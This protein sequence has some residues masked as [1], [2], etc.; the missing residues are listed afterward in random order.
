MFRV[1]DQ[2]EAKVHL[3]QR[4]SHRIGLAR[5]DASE[6][7]DV[8]AADGDQFGFFY[9]ALVRERDR[10]GA[11]LH[12]EA[13]F[14]VEETKQ[15]QV[16]VGCGL[17]GFAVTA[18]EAELEAAAGAGD[19]GQI[20]LAR[21]VVDH[22][23]VGLARLVDGQG[24]AAAA[25][26]QSADA[27]ERQ[28]LRAG[29]QAGPGARRVGLARQQGQTEVGVGQRQAHGVGAAAVDADEGVDAAAP[30]QQ[31]VDRNLG[32]VGIGQGD[33]AAGALETEVARQAGK[34]V[35]THAD[36]AAGAGEFAQR[37]VAVD[38]HGL[39]LAA[40]QH[41]EL[42]AAEVDHHIRGAAGT[43]H[44]TVDLDLQV[45]GA[46]GDAVDAHK[47]HAACARLQ[48]HEVTGC[49][50][51]ADLGGC[52]LLVHQ[53]QTEVDVL[54]AQADA[55]GAATVDAGEGVHASGADGE[56]VHFDGGGGLGVGGV[57]GDHTIVEEDLGAA[58]FNG[59]LPRGLQ[60]AKGVELQ[61]ARRAQQLAV[62]PVHGQLQFA[63]GARGH[64][65]LGVAGIAIAGVGGEAV[66]DH[67][68]TDGGA[69]VDLQQQIAALQGQAV[70][71]HQAGAVGAGLQAGPAAGL[72]LGV[73][74][75]GQREVHT[76]QVQAQ[77][78][79][80][81]A[82]QA[83]EGVEPAAAD[84]EH[85]GLGLAAV[86]ELDGLHRVGF[87]K[88]QVAFELHEAIKVEV[89]MAAGAH[90]C[91]LITRHIQGQ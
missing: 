37:A 68:T 42:L 90:Q 24:D 50:L 67:R 18:L 6:G 60:E 76:T 72:V 87:F 30:H 66:V 7:A 48:G 25:G 31:G 80:L 77:G 79:G 82:V 22:R 91:T 46:S 34:T 29:L 44:A 89:D 69:A 3:A 55:V 74:E 32:A 85:P 14:D 45:A 40:R 19:D 49:G 5:M 1:G 13:A 4:Q 52:E 57:V 70:H 36:L 43:S 54:Q 21:A 81:S 86:G 62:L 35:Q 83:G 27:G 38:D 84:R 23:I 88:G 28:T 71:A 10:L 64:A 75:Q 17:D 11:L 65:E 9:L 78:I 33:G 16:D 59:E 63:V 2:G 41:F 8:A 47:A 56:Q 61:E 58:L 20:G 12:R 39:A 15:V 51:R 26:R 53:R 73:A